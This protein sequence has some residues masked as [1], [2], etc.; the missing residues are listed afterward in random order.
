MDGALG[1]INAL[2][3]ATVEGEGKERIDGVEDKYRAIAGLQDQGNRLLEAEFVFGNDLAAG[4]ARRCRTVALAGRDSHGYRG[5][6]GMLAG[7][8]S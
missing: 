6:T 2:Q 3:E 4:S 5:H 1:S 7:G 8:G